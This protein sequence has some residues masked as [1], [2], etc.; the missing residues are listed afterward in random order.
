MSAAVIRDASITL[1]LEGRAPDA[2][3]IVADAAISSALRAALD[4]LV[5]AA[6]TARAR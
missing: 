5:A 4:T 3:A 2:D 6:F 1:P